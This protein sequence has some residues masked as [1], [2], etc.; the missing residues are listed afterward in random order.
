[1]KKIKAI[2]SHFVFF[3]S[4]GN[5]KI[6]LI[7]L[8]GFLGIF[9][10][11]NVFSSQ[12]V[13][14]I[15]GENGW[16]N[17]SEMNG[18][19]FGSG[20]FGYEAVQLIT[21]VSEIN[22]S[23]DLLV[24]F[25][26]NEIYDS[27]GN[28]KIIYNNLV[29]NSEAVKG[30][31]CALS[32]GLGDG[33][34]LQGGDNALFGKSG[35]AGSFTLEFWLC[36]TVAENGENVFSWRSSRNIG[37]YSEYQMISAV[38]SNN[39]LLWDFTNIFA[40]YKDDV[41][42]L[43]GYSTIVPKKWSR[44]TVSFDE[45]SGILEYMVDGRTE[46]ILYVTDNGHENGSICHPVFGAKASVDICSEYAGKIDNLRFT[47]TPTCRDSKDIFVTGN[48]KYK[49]DGGRFTTEP[50]LVSQSAVMEQVDALMN[51]PQQ[52]EVRLYVRSGDNCYGWTDSYPEWKEILP[53]EKI[54]GVSGLY[55]QV[56]AELLPDGGGSRTPSITELSIKYSE[57]DEPLPPF[58]VQA[59]PG[60][61]CVTLS[62]NYSVDDTAAGYYVYYGNR[63]GEYLGR[64]ALEGSSPVKAGNTTSMTL[65]GLQNGT[66][67]YFAV[68]AYSKI[69]GRINGS[70]SKE[71][72][73]RPSSRLT[74]NK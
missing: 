50:I 21:S 66:I 38:F 44:H 13:M 28:Y 45:E 59:I 4:Y 74:L 12:K 27:T 43:N 10:T 20:R 1:M 73:A 7:L 46:A 23:T 57:H 69:D 64:T 2:L 39:H 33:L 52:T 32:R 70:L 41:I 55:F 14:T 31:G 48:E 63:S 25:D 61:G 19:T 65:T 56:S 11:S 72:Y 42:T 58:I 8:C 9:C 53:G 68:S 6:F 24:S 51:V 15:G 17:L 26:K 34:K 54:T 49:I 40:G 30:T 3:E 35:M 22:D 67:Y 60:D 18:V 71:V 47:R 5:S 29:P 16:K 36:P 37:R 62:W